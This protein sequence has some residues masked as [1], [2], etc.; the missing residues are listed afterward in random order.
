M[1]KAWHPSV[2]P[3]GSRMTSVSVALATYRGT[4]FLGD[5]LQ[6]LARQTRAADQIVVVDDASGDDTAAEVVRMCRELSLPLLLIEN[7]ANMGSTTTFGTAVAACTGNI[8]FFCDQDDVWD[9]QKIQ[10]T[11]AAFADDSGVLAFTDAELVD[12]R[13]R[14]LGRRL[15]RNGRFTDAEQAEVARGGA[16]SVLLRHN[17]ASGATIAFRKRLI[18]LALPIPPAFVHDWWFSLVGAA[19]GRVVA[20]AEPLLRYRQHEG[21]QIGSVSFSLLSRLQRE[22]AIDHT[23][24]VRLELERFVLLGDRLREHGFGSAGDTM[25]AK[26]EHMKTRL[27]ARETGLCSAAVAV[28]REL[29]TGRYR[30]FSSHPLAPV[31]DL[32]R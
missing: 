20:V 19:S 31:R 5:Q 25:D 13:D 11:V 16:L 3:A 28:S 8:I 24:R 30:R 29:L 7:S 23:A 15:W 27:R 10:K 17:V 18:D 32:V 9:P 12:A 22:R 4:R 21:N 2:V 6:S 14:A 26:I 1:A